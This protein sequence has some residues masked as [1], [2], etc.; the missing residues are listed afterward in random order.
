VA[1]ELVAPDTE[2]DVRG[3]RELPRVDIV[4]SYA[5]AG[6]TAVR[7]FVAAGAGAGHAGADRDRRRATDSGYVR[8]V[9]TVNE[10]TGCYQ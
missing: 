6:G 10:R 7:A 1:D 8:R 5:G 2:F 3:V 4:Y 9:L